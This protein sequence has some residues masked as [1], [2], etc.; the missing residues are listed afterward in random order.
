MKYITES[1][2]PYLDAVLSDRFI[3]LNM[4]KDGIWLVDKEHSKW[5]A[6]KETAL[7]IAKTFGDKKTVSTLELL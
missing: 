6:I 2:I 5:D 4:W 7:N 3:I 1:E